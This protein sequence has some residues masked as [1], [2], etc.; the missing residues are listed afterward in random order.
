M[1]AE[2]GIMSQRGQR[3]KGSLRFLHRILRMDEDR[4]TRQVFECVKSDKKKG[5]EA[6]ENW[7]SVTMKEIIRR[8]ELQWPV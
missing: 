3:D 1:R 5:K 8:H 7:V 2:L 6:K 4:L